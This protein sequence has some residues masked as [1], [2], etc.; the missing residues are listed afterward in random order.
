MLIADGLCV[1]ILMPTILVD[2][3]SPETSVEVDLSL[4]N[5]ASTPSLPDTILIPPP[6]IIGI[7]EPTVLLLA[8]STRPSW[9][10]ALKKSLLSG[11]STASILASLEIAVERYLAVLNPLHY[12]EFV[13]KS[14]VLSTSAVG[15][16]IVIGKTNTT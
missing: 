15:A 3:V 9:G 11:V 7:P 13:T 8:G 16:T 6:S 12:H 1:V 2:L 4:Q 5:L 10:C 14:G